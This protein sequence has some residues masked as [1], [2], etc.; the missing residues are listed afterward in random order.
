MFDL[1]LVTWNQI[2]AMNENGNSKILFVYRVSNINIMFLLS[3]LHV[4]FML[5]LEIFHKCV[6]ERYIWPI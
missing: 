1:F 5:D 6:W 2:F 3:L 4:I